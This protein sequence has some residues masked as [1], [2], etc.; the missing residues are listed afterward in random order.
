MYV[1]EKCCCKSTTYIETSKRF[2]IGK[3]LR[4]LKEKKLNTKNK[5]TISNYDNGIIKRY[6]SIIKRLVMYF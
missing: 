4:I 2:Y 6:Y 3:R 5:T 1:V